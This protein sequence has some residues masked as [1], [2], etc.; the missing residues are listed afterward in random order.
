MKIAIFLASLSGGGA[1]KMMVKVA[2]YLSR[3]GY[4]VDLIVCRGDGEYLSFVDAKVNIITFNVKRVSRS[5]FKLRNYLQRVNPEV[6]LSAMNYVNAT[7]AVAIFLARCKTRHVASERSHFSSRYS[8]LSPIRKLLLT[9]FIGW[10]YSRCDKVIAISK[11][12]KTDL[13]S[14]INLDADKV[15]VIYNP[16]YP[17]DLCE[18]I[19]S[20]LDDSIMSESKKK[21]ILCVGRLE[22]AKG[23][24]NLLKSFSL[25]S[26]KNSVELI[27]MGQGSLESS[28]KEYSKKL[29]I[30]S[31]VKFI[32]FQINPYPFLVK[33]DLFVLPSEFEG[34][35]NVLVEAMACGTKIVSTDCPSGPSEILENGRW[36]H[37]VPVNDS[38]ALAL[39]MQ[40]SL[41]IDDD[42][43]IELKNRSR[44]F[45]MEKI[46]RQ[47]LDVLL[48]N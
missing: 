11:G 6:L 25:I 5:I 31:S 20:P 34:F 45:S 43:E 1:E 36:G 40:N 7:A 23:F 33:A 28:L 2:N 9:K 17:D 15:V 42:R 4:D 22:P 14:E 13:C 32:G 38:A 27:M 30:E 3:L 44:D 16:A 12:V 8:S 24:F 26:G 37:L 35:G 39:A 46:G 47:Y 19:M 18:L 48:P 10:C 29:G 21:Y 41:L